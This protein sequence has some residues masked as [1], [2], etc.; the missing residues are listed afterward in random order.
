MELYLLDNTLETALVIPLLTR[1]VRFFVPVCGVPCDRACARYPRHRLSS[2]EFRINIGR[3][4]RCSEKK[5]LA[6]TGPS[7]RWGT[8]FAVAKKNLRVS[9]GAARSFDSLLLSLNSVCPFCSR[10][11]P[12]RCYM[13]RVHFFKAEHACR[14]RSA[15]CQPAG[16]LHLNFFILASRNFS[17]F[18]RM[19]GKGI[20]LGSK[21]NLLFSFQ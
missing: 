1:T 8:R 12:W 5:S 17:S 19:G 20:F 15:R 11:S 4:R 6:R 9:G 14:G 2:I 18:L 16:N 10:F 13:P 3:K 21:R 7:P